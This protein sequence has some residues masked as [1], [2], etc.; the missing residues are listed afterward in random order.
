[1]KSQKS[2]CGEFNRNVEVICILRNFPGGL[3]SDKL[4]PAR[5]II[6]IVGLLCGSNEANDTAV[7]GVEEL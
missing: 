6:T 5:P 1:M 4:E 7:N 3:L 2:E